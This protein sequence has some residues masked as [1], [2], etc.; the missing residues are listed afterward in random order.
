[1]K[2]Q[3]YVALDAPKCPW[4]CPESGPT[5]L[6]HERFLALEVGNDVWRTSCGHLVDGEHNARAHTCEKVPAVHAPFP[7]V[8]R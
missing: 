7:A 8:S 3:K 6:S 5:A 1:M 2:N 4:G